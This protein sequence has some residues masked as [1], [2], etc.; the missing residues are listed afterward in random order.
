[1]P[2]GLGLAEALLVLLAMA[3]PVG[4]V[5]LLVKTL[6]RGPAP[7][8]LRGAHERQLAAELDSAHARVEELQA[9]LARVEEKVAFNED[10]LGD[11]RGRP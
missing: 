10:L 11:G 8:R 6:S 7:D 9:K 3:V 5:V 4:A 2:F 1:M